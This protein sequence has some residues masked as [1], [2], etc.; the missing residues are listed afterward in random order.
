MSDQTVIG[1]DYEN[2]Y[3]HIYVTDGPLD[4]KVDAITIDIPSTPENDLDVQTIAD[5]LR[6]IARRLETRDRTKHP[7][8]VVQNLPVTRQHDGITVDGSILLERG[9]VLL[10]DIDNG[11]AQKIIPLEPPR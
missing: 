3:Y 6:R 8:A 9:D 5:A 11:T 2:G 4:G 10:V 1:W 7:D